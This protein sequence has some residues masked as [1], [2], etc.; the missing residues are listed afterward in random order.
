[1]PVT[2]SAAKALRRDRRRASHN[3]VLR[4]ELRSVIKDAKKLRTPAAIKQ[5]ISVIDKAAQ[6][7]IIHPNKASRLKSQLARITPEAPK[8]ASKPS[9]T[10]KTKNIVKKAKPTTKSTTGK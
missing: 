5:A 2:T 6:K 10:K 1:M 9:P 3:L 7:G 4:S 8:A